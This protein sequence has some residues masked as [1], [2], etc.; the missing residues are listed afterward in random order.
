MLAEIARFAGEFL[1]RVERDE[2]GRDRLLVLAE[3]RG[4]RPDR[5]LEATMAVLLRRRL[6]IEVEIE[7]H[8][9]GALAHLTGIEKRQKPIRLIDNRKARC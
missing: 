5:E 1:C 7:L 4:E 8:A 9:P 3:V 6:G 2:S